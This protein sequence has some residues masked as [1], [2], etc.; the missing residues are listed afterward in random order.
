[1]TMARQRAKKQ[2]V[3]F[4]ITE[5]DVQFPED[6]LCPVLG[7]PLERNV[8]GKA[9]SDNSPSLDRVKPS[10]GYVPGNVIVISSKANRI[11]S[12]ANPFELGLVAKFFIDLLNKRNKCEQ[13]SSTATSSPSPSL[14]A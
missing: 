13:S 11:K 8:G 14:P 4:T 1:M 7:I 9:A 5:D 2:G 12:N 6:M 3:S 10:L